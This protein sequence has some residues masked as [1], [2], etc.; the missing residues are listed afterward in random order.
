MDCWLGNG[1]HPC[2]VCLSISGTHEPQRDR[3]GHSSSDPMGINWHSLWSCREWLNHTRKWPRVESLPI[4]GTCT[5]QEGVEDSPR[6]EYL[7]LCLCVVSDQSIQEGISF[8]DYK[9]SNDRREFPDPIIRHTRIPPTTNVLLES[10]PHIPLDRY[11]PSITWSSTVT[12]GLW[13][14]QRRKNTLAQQLMPTYSSRPWIHCHA[15]V[16][17]SF[18]FHHHHP[19]HQRTPENTCGVVVGEGVMVVLFY[20]PV[21]HNKNI[22]MMMVIIFCLTRRGTRK[23]R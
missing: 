19:T 2:T 23:E 6:D 4:K 1:H 14:W 12:D 15:S 21:K 16:T 17:L 13:P 11:P 9:R 20:C 7:S 3:E 5:H 10:H 8:V 18:T 22:I